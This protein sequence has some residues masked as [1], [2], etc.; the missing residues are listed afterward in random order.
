MPA[1]ITITGTRATGHRPPDEY[2]AV[3]SEYLAPF[4]RETTHFYV[5]G[6]SGVDSLALL[7]LATET[8]ST[9]SVAVP[10]TVADQP[11]DARQAIARSDEERAR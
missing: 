8:R 11:S 9:I 1:T 10:G 6:A 2:D 4:A 7:W 3:F 5:G